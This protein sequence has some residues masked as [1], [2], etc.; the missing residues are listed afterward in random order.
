MSI[1]IRKKVPLASYTTFKIGGPAEF[2]AEIKDKDDLLNSLSWARKNNQKVFILGGGSNLLISDQ[3]ISGLVLFLKKNDYKILDKTSEKKIGDKIRISA[4]A[5]VMLSGLALKLAENDLSGLEW[6]VGIPRA[7][8]GGSVRGN[9]GAFGVSMGDLVCE[10]EVFDLDKEEFKTFYFED[11]QFAYR[12]SVF[13]KDKKY[14][15]WNVILKMKRKNKAEI[16]KLIEKSIQHRKNSYP[17]FPSAGSVFKNTAQIE[18]VRQHDFEVAREAEESGAVSENGIV[19]SGF[20]I[21]RFGLKGKKIGGA[22]V[23]E[24]HANFIINTGNATAENVII[25]M[26]LIKQKIRDN[27]GVQLEEE[28][29]LVGF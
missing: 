27:Y 1:E 10:V 17:K 26:S 22:K 15:I 3:G 21:E 24:R 18:T 23:S 16:E 4:G 29:E 14:L 8:V 5:G 2:F 6:S 13:K 9:A 7:T 28:I 11:C 25:L 19:P 12:E 20:L